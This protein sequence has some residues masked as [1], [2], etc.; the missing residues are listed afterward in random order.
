MTLKEYTFACDSRFRITE[1]IVVF[2]IVESLYNTFA[3][4]DQ[5][6]AE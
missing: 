5:Q 1:A 6:L 3:G 2:G 4:D